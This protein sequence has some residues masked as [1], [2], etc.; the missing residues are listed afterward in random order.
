MKEYFTTLATWQKTSLN[1]YAQ[2]TPNG[3]PEAIFGRLDGKK[4]LVRSRD[5][6]EHIT[7]KRFMT[8]KPISQGDLLEIDGVSYEIKSV[9]TT[10]DIDGKN[11]VYEAFF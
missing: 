10:P 8:D 6:A 7:E 4:R 11:P 1:E 2:T 9:T 5:G 3:P